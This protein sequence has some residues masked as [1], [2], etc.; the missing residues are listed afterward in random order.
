MGIYGQ[1]INRLFLRKQFINRFYYSIQGGKN[2]IPR[3]DDLKRIRKKS[4][5]IKNRLLK[6]NRLLMEKGILQE[7]IT[8]KDTN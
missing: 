2:E 1:F 4:G 6:N 5:K 3:Y 8:P 7:I